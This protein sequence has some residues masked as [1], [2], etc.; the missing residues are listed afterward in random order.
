MKEMNV[1]KIVGAVLVAALVIVAIKVITNHLYGNEGGE[2]AP[3]PA[4]QAAPAAP[5]A[6]TKT[7][8][9]PAESPPA[10]PAAPAKEAAPAAPAEAPAAPAAAPAAPAAA[11]AAPAQTAAA[12]AGDADAGANLFKSHLCFACHS[13]EPGKNG[14]GP[15]LAGVYGRKAAQAPGFDYSAGLKNS[16]I[17][18]DEATI[19]K[20]VQGPQKVVSDAKMMLA[21][22]V[23]DATDRANLIAYIKR[24]S[25]KSK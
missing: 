23:T 13:F 3:E 9:K 1:V 16:G 11:P 22:P 20:W 24:E 18:W 2:G 8:E 4:Q 17:T 19:D 10:Q 12:G 5:P 7:A 6:A 21:K 15:S 25:A 14:A